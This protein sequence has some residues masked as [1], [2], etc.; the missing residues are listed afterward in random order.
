MILLP[1]H[2]RLDAAN[3]VTRGILDDL[4]TRSDL[5]AAIAQEIRWCLDAQFYRLDLRLAPAEDLAALVGPLD[6]IIAATEKAGPA[7][8]QLPEF[9]PA[10]LAKLRELRALLRVD[11]PQ[12][13]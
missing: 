2:R 10:Y 7:S 3:W 5:P 11:P 4:A 1:D 9:F 6:E 13:A 12:G 8:F